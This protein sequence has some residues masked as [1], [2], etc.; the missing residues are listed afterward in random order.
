MTQGEYAQAAVLAQRSLEKHPDDAELK[1]LA[2]EAALKAELPAWLA[3]LRARDFDGMRAVLASVSQ[4][5]KGNTDLQQLVGELEWLGKLEQL[6]ISRG[7]PDAPI[8]IYADEDR[9]AALLDRWN[10]GTREH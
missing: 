5:G 1:A 9:I 7:G 4:L 8:R 3:K 2:T 6:V 10:D